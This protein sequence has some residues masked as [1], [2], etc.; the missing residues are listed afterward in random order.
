MVH[1]YNVS[2]LSSYYTGTLQK[3]EKPIADIPTP[4]SDMITSTTQV[5]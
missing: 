4:Y 3:N 2:N 1:V 5:K